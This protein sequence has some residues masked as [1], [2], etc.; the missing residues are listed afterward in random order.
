MKPL[1]TIKNKTTMWS[2][3][4]TSGYRSKGNEYL[5]QK[6]NYTTMFIVAPFTIPRYRK[7]LS[8]HKW[9]NE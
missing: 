1:Q 3:N 8:V 2:S 9:M 4:P 6:Y 5:Y 7:N